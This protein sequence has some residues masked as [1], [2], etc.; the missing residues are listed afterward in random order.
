MKLNMISDIQKYNLILLGD[1]L[2][3]N[4]HYELRDDTSSCPAAELSYMGYVHFN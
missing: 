3:D 4:H 1:S 2:A